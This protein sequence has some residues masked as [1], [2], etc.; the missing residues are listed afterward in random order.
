MDKG[1]GYEYILSVTWIGRRF[2]YNLPNRL[3]KVFFFIFCVLDLTPFFKHIKPMSLTG[4]NYWI[5]KKI[6]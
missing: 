5:R 1:P 4:D 2:I 6:S 3:F